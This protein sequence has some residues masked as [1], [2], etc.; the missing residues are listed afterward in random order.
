MK[1]IIDEEYNRFGIAQLDEN[2]V[3]RLVSC[4]EENNIKCSKY[5]NSITIALTYKDIKFVCL[6]YDP[7]GVPEPSPQICA[8]VFPDKIIFADC[9]SH[10]T[11]K[12]GYHESRIDGSTGNPELDELFSKMA[13]YSPLWSEYSFAW[14][15]D[16]LS[17]SENCYP[18]E[19]EFEELRCKII[20]YEL[21]MQKKYL[22]E[23][24]VRPY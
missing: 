19:E 7:R 2:E 11:D 1:E 12:N 17:D 23:K 13:F 14:L 10:Y 3:R 18:Y 15:V 5:N 21:E 24:T 16:T 6:S 4:M 9:F 8:A 20:E 22:T